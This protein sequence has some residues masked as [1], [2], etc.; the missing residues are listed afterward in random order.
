MAK[1]RK[2]DQRRGENSAVR[3]NRSQHFIAAVHR[4]GTGRRE[5]KCR[6]GA[7]FNPG[8]VRTLRSN[9]CFHVF[10]KKDADLA[11]E[12]LVTYSTISDY[13]EASYLAPQ[14]LRFNLPTPPSP[15][16]RVC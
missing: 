5:H 9:A 14:L 11:A 4:H 10:F 6:A 2:S 13:H 3:S 16:R 8:E 7:G 12:R 15:F 1:E